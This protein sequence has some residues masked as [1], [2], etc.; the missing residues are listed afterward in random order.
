MDVLD[1]S[2][3]LTTAFL[4]STLKTHTVP[5]NTHSDHPEQ[6]FKIPPPLFFTGR[7]LRPA[8]IGIEAPGPGRLT[9]DCFQ[10]FWQP[11]EWQNSPHFVADVF[12]RDFY[13]TAFRSVSSVLPSN[14]PRSVS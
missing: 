7:K 12:S 5:C 2:L 9:N 14:I 13:K 3:S 11:M 1:C 10:Q 6:K 8:G 4:Q